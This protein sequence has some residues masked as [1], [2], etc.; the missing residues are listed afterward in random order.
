MNYHQLDQQRTQPVV[1]Q[2]QEQAPAANQ[3]SRPL[4]N[5]AVPPDPRP[6]FDQQRQAIQATDPGRPL[7]PQQM[8]NVRQNQPAGPSQEHEAPH[9]APA[10]A[11][12]TQPA[13][14]PHNNP[15]T[16]PAPSRHQ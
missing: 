10:A 13:P 12:A 14:A 6:S 7:S 4:Y 11:P 3:T 16:T 9:P 5:R 15:P 2:P 1:Q 8:N